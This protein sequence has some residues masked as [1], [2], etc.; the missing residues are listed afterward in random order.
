MY[1]VYKYILDTLFPNRCISCKR[2]GFS[3]CKRCLDKIPRSER[4]SN[5]TIAIFTYKNKN[6][7]HA[8]WNLKYNGRSTIAEDLSD[9]M[10]DALF[11][12]LEDKAIFDNFKEI[13]LVPLPMSKNR[14]RSRGKNHAL[15]LAS[16]I[17][18][19]T[20]F[21]VLDCL[22]KTKDTKRQALIKNRSK[23]L[24]NVKNS[25]DLKNGFNVI[26]K[27]IVLVDDIVTTGATIEEAKRVLRKSGAKNI[28]ALVVA[29]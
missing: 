13:H 3:I 10:K 4:L 25:M 11:G 21:P 20:N 26:G 28:I 29:H 19:K 1:R 8:L 16:A 22:I 9:Y 23:R 15:T 18:R 27:N 7:S 24:L 14:K 17:S 6:I 12:E 5:D 2:E